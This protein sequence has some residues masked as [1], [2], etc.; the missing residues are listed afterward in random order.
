MKLSQFQAV[1]RTVSIDLG[2]DEP[3]KVRY[4]PAK[5]NKTLQT[6]LTAIQRKAEERQAKGETIEE[7]ESAAARLLIEL[8]ADWDLTDDNGGAVPITES[9]LV[10]GLGYI[11]INTITTALIG[12]INPNA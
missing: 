7:E 9:V 1:T 11:N 5:F 2:A 12:A 3:L 4:Y 8:A 6:R 10:D